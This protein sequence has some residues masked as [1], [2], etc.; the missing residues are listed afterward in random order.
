MVVHWGSAA[1][2]EDL[3]R[4]HRPGSEGKITH[5]KAA[6]S[7]SFQTTAARLYSVVTCGEA[8]DYGHQSED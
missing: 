2:P 4:D 6:H 7:P 3:P 1:D 5:G 8:V